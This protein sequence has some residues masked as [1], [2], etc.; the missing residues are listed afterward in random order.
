MVHRDSWLWRSVLTTGRAFRTRW[1]RSAC[2]LDKVSEA[3][4]SRQQT[5]AALVTL[6]AI[7]SLMEECPSVL[8]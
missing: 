5:V 4:Q 1:A 2:V 8:A 3:E 6:D 7:K